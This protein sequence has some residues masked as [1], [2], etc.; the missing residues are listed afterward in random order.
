[1]LQ[2]L[3]IRAKLLVVAV[4]AVVGTVALTG[5][6]LF[7]ERSNSAALKNV[8]E[9]TVVPLVALQK[10]NDRLGEIH[11]RISGV[12]LDIMPVQGSL[13]HLRDSRRDLEADWAL[14]KANSQ[15]FQGAEQA[16][17]YEAVINGVPA[18]QATLDKVD[19]AYQ[20]TDNAA[21]TKILE[22]DWAVAHKSYVKPLIAL[23]PLQESSAKAVY[24]EAVAKN[25]VLTILSLTIGIVCAVL[26]ASVSFLVIRGF[27]QSMSR[28]RSAAD[29]IA[30]GNLAVAIDTTAAD[31]VGEMMRRLE[32]MRVALLTVVSSVR[33]GCESVNVA[34]REIAQGNSDLST[35]TEQ[36]A[37]GLQQTAAS[38]QEMAGT[39][40]K[41]SESATE[42]NDLVRT[43]SDVAVRG[44][45]VVLQVV[46]TM[47]EINKQSSKISEIISV[48]DGI[49]FQ[50]NILALNAAVEAARAGDQGR[51]FAVVAGEVR[52]LAQRS[53]L[54]AKEIKDLISNNVAQV[55]SGSALVAEAGETMNEIVA[56][57][58]SVTAIIGEMTVATLQQ[59]AGLGQINQAISQMDHMTQQNSALVEQGAAAAESLREQA[60]RLVQAVAAFRLG[61]AV[62]LGAASSAPKLGE[63]T[64]INRSKDIVPP[65][66]SKKA[67]Q[68]DRHLAHVASAPKITSVAATSGA[69]DWSEF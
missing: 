47:D 38:M 53:A 68:Q 9:N 43:A 19:A 20:A 41:N 10:I 31:E 63:R 12:L 18:V 61:N 24:Q 49:A 40:K 39:V 50:T 65:K 30:A 27:V 16:P 37:S 60:D 69:D 52:N 67:G 46:S 35:R 54:A 45:A 13:N 55:R 25:Q 58:Q 11:F 28:A 8:Y 6:N 29:E 2:N 51:G 5:V 17:L 3:S 57:V 62:D 32:A 14:I 34:S 23:I 33:E 64:S 59:N 22:D 21:L 1:M 44:G 42:A 15:Q 66:F 56:Q 26:V 4:A 7:S 36:Q 48:I